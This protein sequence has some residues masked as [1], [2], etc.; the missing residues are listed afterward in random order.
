ME[1]SVKGRR[2]ALPPSVQRPHHGHGPVNTLDRSERAKLTCLH[3][4]SLVFHHNSDGTDTLSK[5]KLLQSIGVRLLW[6]RALWSPRTSA[7]DCQTWCLMS[8]AYCC[9]VSHL[10]WLL[11]LNF[12][13]LLVFIWHC[14]LFML[15]SYILTCRLHLPLSEAQLK[16]SLTIF[17]TIIV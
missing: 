14:I 13:P 11:G 9:N 15:I 7:W 8:L 2:C 17:K 10:V 4:P 1:A 12:A 5:G 3:K 6:G 16:S